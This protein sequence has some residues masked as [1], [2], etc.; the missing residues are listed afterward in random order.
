MNILEREMMVLLKELKEN[1]DVIAIKAEFEAEASRMIELSRLKDVTSSVSLPLIMKIGG[2]EA[3]TDIYNCLIIGVAGIVAP[4]A[5]TPYAIS[6]FVNAIQTF[7]PPDNREDI[8]FAVNIETITAYKNIDEIL[9]VN[10]I[11]LLSSI[12]VG[13][14]DFTSSREL[15]QGSVNSKEMF[16]ICRDIFKKAKAR[17]LKT[18][19]GGKILVDSIPFLKQ[20]NEMNLINKFETRKVVFKNTALDENIRDGIIKAIEFELLWLKSKKRYYSRAKVEDDVRIERLEKHLLD[21]GA[22]KAGEYYGV[23]K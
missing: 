10:G 23:H 12:T 11:D 21:Y 16:E 15:G 5:E 22:V 3:I 7:V 20:L 8:E 18:T 4:M 2:V 1:Y 6:K 9:N 17:G 13:R 14:S 19:I